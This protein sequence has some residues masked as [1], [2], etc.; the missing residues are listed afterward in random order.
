MLTLREE[1]EIPQAYSS[2]YNKL[3]YGKKLYLKYVK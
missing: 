3:V 1:K 2:I